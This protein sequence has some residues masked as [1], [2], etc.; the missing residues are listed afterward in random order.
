[1]AEETVHYR[2]KSILVSKTAII[3]TLAFIAAILAEPTYIAVL[4]KVVLP[5]I[6]I[7]LP[8]IN[9]FL[10]TQT[11]RPVAFIGPNETKVVT[12]DKLK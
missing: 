6:A 3:N 5:V 2:A 8:P 4:P 11:E 12:V 10:R 1:M 9:F 7:L